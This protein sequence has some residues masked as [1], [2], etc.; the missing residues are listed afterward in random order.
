MLH[1]F[2]EKFGA[3]WSNL[4]QFGAIWSKKIRALLLP[5]I[6]LKRGRINIIFC[7]NRCAHECDSSPLR[8]FSLDTALLL[9]FQKIVGIDE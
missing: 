2:M 7:V 4:E 5:I 3:I 8:A 6:H 9:L 1:M